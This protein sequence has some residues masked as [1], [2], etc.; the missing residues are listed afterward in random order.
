[1]GDEAVTLNDYPNNPVERFVFIE[2][3][4]HVGEWDRALKLS[5]ES[6]KISKEYVG[7]LLCTLWERI[8]TETTGGL[9]ND[10]QKRSEAISGAKN[11]F[12]CNP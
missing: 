7:P 4:T 6:Y 10:A 1:L 3:Y 12:A 2:G 8:E 9:E 5:R 11:L